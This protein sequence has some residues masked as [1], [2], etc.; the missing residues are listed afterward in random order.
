ME[1]T[2]QKK[3]S[4]LIQQELSEIMAR[5]LEVP[6]SPM[7]TV[8]V[9]RSAPDLRVVKV[10]VSIFPDD[11]QDEAMEWLQENLSDV[12]HKL[13]VRIR[14]QV[15]YIPEIMLFLDDSMQ[16]SEHIESLLRDISGNKDKS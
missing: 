12:R 11:K 3:F 14:H 13:A 10:Y 7:L 5:E 1:S 9:V 2:R 6:G 15:R 4:R 16:E 8:S